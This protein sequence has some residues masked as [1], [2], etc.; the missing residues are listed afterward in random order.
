MLLH[1]HE[2][3]SRSITLA[4]AYLMLSQV[5]CSAQQDS[6]T[7]GLGPGNGDAKMS[8]ASEFAHP[9]A[10]APAHTR[11]LHVG[12]PV[13]VY[14]W[15]FILKRVQVHAV[16]NSYVHAQVRV[17]TVK[18]IFSE[19]LAPALPSACISGHAAC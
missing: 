16:Q 1:C 9:H 17:L 3:V 7:C 14:A 13:R 15:L 11:S 6:G 19:A 12:S 8:C 4:L 5:W 10:H 2:G 18:K